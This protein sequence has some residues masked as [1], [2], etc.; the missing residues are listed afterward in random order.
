MSV[1]VCLRGILRLIRV[2]TLRLGHNVGIL[3]EGLNYKEVLMLQVCYAEVDNS[4]I[5][6]SHYK[7][8]HAFSM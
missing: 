2:D 5:C 6:K 1:R 3:A 7:Y 4:C 8:C